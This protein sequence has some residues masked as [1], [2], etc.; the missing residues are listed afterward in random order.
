M[1]SCTSS[2]FSSDYTDLAFRR[3]RRAFSL[4]NGCIRFHNTIGM[5]YWTISDTK[6]YQNLL[7]I[8]NL[9][10]QILRWQHWIPL[11]R[12]KHSSFEDR[13]VWWYTPPEYLK[14][15]WRVEQSFLEK[16]KP[17]LV[18]ID[19]FLKLAHTFRTVHPNLHWPNILATNFREFHW[20]NMVAKVWQINREF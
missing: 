15:Y 9:V 3:W 12:L 4:R 17:H 8:Q 11:Q 10:S 14:P 13:Q 1:F 2:L 16:T 18:G 5:R 7:V 20:Q 19:G 6:S